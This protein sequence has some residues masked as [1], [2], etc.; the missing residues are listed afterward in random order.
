MLCESEP[1]ERNVCGSINFHEQNKKVL[2]KKNRFSNRLLEEKR[3]LFDISLSP[4]KPSYLKF[5]K[6]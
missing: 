3:I 5:G 1:S 4:Q 2:L 6:S